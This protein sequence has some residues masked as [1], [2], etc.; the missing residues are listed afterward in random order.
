LAE[1]E[2]YQ[3]K[4]QLTRFC[5]DES[6]A[7]IVEWAL[8]AGLVAVVSAGG[9][10]GP[11]GST[12]NGLLHRL[13]TTIASVF[14]EAVMPR[15]THGAAVSALAKSNSTGADVATK[16]KSNSGHAGNDHKRGA[17]KI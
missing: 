14:D 13:E 17:R 4:K 12:V 2:C 6:G 3:M 8:V 7:E 10:L 16:A 1:G 9:Y 5:R 11:I 15:S